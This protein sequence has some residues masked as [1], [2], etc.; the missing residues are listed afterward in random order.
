MIKISVLYKFGIP[1][2]PGFMVTYVRHLLLHQPFIRVRIC[3]RREEYR[4]LTNNSEEYT[5]NDKRCVFMLTVVWSNA[6]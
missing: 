2:A 6:L 4:I 5:F 1:H 3:L